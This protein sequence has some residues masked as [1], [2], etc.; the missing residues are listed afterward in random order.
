MSER[1]HLDDEV[2]TIRAVTFEEIVAYL[3]EVGA[4]RPCE[5]CRNEGWAVGMNDGKP[6]LSTLPSLNNESVTITFLLMCKKCG[7]TRLIAAKHAAKAIVDMRAK[8]S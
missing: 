8:S 5:A 1:L 6:V 4:T 2:E 7:N 3:T